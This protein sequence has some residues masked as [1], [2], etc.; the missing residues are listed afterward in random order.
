MKRN[1]NKHIVLG[2]VLLGIITLGFLSCGGGAQ[3]GN[4]AGDVFMYASKTKFTHFDPHVA[5]TT[6][7]ANFTYQVYES[8]IMR[9]AN[10]ELEMGLGLAKSWELMSETEWKFILHKGV[11]FHD[12]AD[13]TAEDVV[14]SFK[15]GAE[16]KEG[17]SSVAKNMVESVEVIDDYTV[18]IHTN[19][20]I[21]VF[22][23]ALTSIQIADKDWL[24]E[25]SP[26][27]ITTADANNY[28]RD[29]ANGTG[30]YKLMSLDPSGEVIF[31]KFEGYRNKANAGHIKTIKYITIEDDAT[32]IASLISGQVD[33]IFPVPIQDWKSIESEDALKLVKNIEGRPIF[34]GLDQFSDVL[35]GAEDGATANPF[36]D[37]RV[38]EA[39][40]LAID[41]QTINDQH[42]EGNGYPIGILSA[43]GLGGHPKNVAIT[44]PYPYDVKRAKELMKEAGYE[45]GFSVT[46]NAPNNRYVKDEAMAA[47]IVVMLAKI[48]ITVNL[49]TEPRS[50]YFDRLFNKRAVS[51]YMLGWGP[52]AAHDFDI[53]TRL[54]SYPD[55]EKKLGGYNIGQYKNTAINTISEQLKDYKYNEQ[56]NALISEAYAISKKDFAYVPLLAPPI[57]VAAKKSFDFVLSPNEE[58]R[59]SN[60][61]AIE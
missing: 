56:F 22:P 7:Q 49:E 58:I 30:P 10:Y 37:K 53:V 19:G 16:A 3:S 12:G 13:F 55:E 47:S 48:N 40:N 38:R 54:L 50:Q 43:P 23:S 36:K 29:H 6:T 5:N 1:N 57:S 39:I 31:E 2:I 33:L 14:A 27:A 44:S 52:I 21:P 4:K 51:M 15:R 24:D 18:V 59:F 20:Y 46:F 35:L 26:T 34:L 17:G 42:L 28:T 41:I 60:I 9:N 61:I 45:N 32:R 8:L 11:K 25:H